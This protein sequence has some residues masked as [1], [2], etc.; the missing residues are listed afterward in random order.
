MNEKAFLSSLL[1]MLLLTSTLNFAFVIN[2]SFAEH[3]ESNLQND[4]LESINQ[5]ALFNETANSQ[6]LEKNSQTIQK[7]A[8]GLPEKTLR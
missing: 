2:S 7:E 5:A 6:I 8:L 3:C 4:F 1:L